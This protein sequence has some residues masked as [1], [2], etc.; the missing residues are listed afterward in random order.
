VSKSKFLTNSAQFEGKLAYKTSY[1]GCLSN[2]SKKNALGNSND[3]NFII[4]GGASFNPGLGVLD[5]SP[6]GL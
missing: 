2:S 5:I 6:P 3:R 1:F 4:G